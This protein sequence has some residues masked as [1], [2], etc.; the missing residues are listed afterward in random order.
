MCG[1]SFRLET[2]GKG[3]DS[4]AGGV[5]VLVEVLGERW[6]DVI[7]CSKRVLLTVESLV[8]YIV[9]IIVMRDLNHLYETMLAGAS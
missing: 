3:V 4:T 8:L 2:E 5:C 7:G 6:T 1:R 9:N